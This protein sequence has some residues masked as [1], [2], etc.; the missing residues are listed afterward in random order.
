MLLSYLTLM[1]ESRKKLKKIL[2]S[3]PSKRQQK[4]KIN[5]LDGRKNRSTVPT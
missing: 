3:T 5:I 1:E 4:H 2:K